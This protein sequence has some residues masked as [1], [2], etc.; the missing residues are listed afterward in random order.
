MIKF[1]IEV[2]FGHPVDNFDVFSWDSC[3]I[4]F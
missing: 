3:L 1:N 2:F 4:M